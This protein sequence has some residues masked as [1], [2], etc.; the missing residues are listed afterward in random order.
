VRAV[1]IL[2]TSGWA[3][4]VWSSASARFYAIDRTKLHARGTLGW[5]IAGC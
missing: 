3:P 2:H 1:E 4:L 5:I